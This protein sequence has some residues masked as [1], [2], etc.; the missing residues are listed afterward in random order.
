VSGVSRIPPEPRI[1]RFLIVWL[2]PKQ[3]PVYYRALS[4]VGWPD[5]IYVAVRTRVSPTD[6]VAGLRREVWAIDSRVTITNVSSASELIA[7]SVAEPRFRT[8]VLS[9]FGVFAML[10]AV[11]G[12]YGVMAYT[13]GDR[14]REIGIRMALGVHQGNIVKLV[15]NTGL[16]LTA[17]GVGAGVLAALGLTR[18]IESMLFGLAANDLVTFGVVALVLGGVS[19]LATY[20]P[21]RRAARID[22]LESL[23]YE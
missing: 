22:P 8:L 16:G 11:V 20:L 17:I 21:A 4:Q 15:L 2:T 7:E 13:V 5:R 9:T 12:I 14:T 1:A 19:L 10:L 23:R 6:L 3:Q 18:F